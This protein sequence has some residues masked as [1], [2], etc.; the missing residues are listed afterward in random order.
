MDQFKFALGPYELFA[1][2]IGGLPLSLAICLAYNPAMNLQNM[3]TILQSNA[4]TQILLVLILVSYLLGGLARSIT[5]KYFLRLCQIFHEDYR[6]FGNL[7]D[8]HVKPV[9]QIRQSGDLD[10]LD[11]EDKLILCLHEKIGK[12]PKGTYRLTTWLNS[13]LKE[14][15][16]PSAITSESYLATHIMYRNLSFGFLLIGVVTFLNLFR[17]RLFAVDVILVIVVAIALAY[18][19]FRQAVS[20]K[21]WSERELFLGFYFSSLK[22]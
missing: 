13:Y 22:P 12:L 14:Q 2:I 21:R 8:N 16:R 17:L 9:E 15:N 20:F 1:S 10:T 18:T 4:S 3:L 19:A 5:W 11:F 6:Y 7:F